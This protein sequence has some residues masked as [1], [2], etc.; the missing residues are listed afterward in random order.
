MLL[1]HQRINV[2]LAYAALTQQLA[3]PA[4]LP[5]T[6]TLDMLRPEPCALAA[7]IPASD[8]S[9]Q[10]GITGGGLMPAAVAAANSSL[11]SIWP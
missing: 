9:A 2:P 5:L 1:L 4:C 11:S 6:M 10:A 7:M 8:S 3:E